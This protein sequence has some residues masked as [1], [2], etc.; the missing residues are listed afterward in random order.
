MS[1]V[2]YPDFEIKKKLNKY[3]KREL[4]QYAAN[5]SHYIIGAANHMRFAELGNVAENEHMIDY[6]R[7]HCGSH[8]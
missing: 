6:V 2:L 7:E 4:V 3:S 1:I 5:V 8:V